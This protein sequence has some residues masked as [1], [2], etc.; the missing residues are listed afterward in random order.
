MLLEAY[1]SE[2]EPPSAQEVRRGDTQLSTII[3]VAGRQRMLT[4][5]M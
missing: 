4:Q 3:N 5:R 1:A 2:Q